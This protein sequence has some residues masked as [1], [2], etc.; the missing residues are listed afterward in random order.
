MRNLSAHPGI[1]LGL[2]RGPIR[3]VR[4]GTCIF[5][6]RA[7]ITYGAGRVRCGTGGVHICP[8]P[9][10]IAPMCKGDRVVNGPVGVP[11]SYCFRSEEESGRNC[12]HFYLLCEVRA[13]TPPVVEWRRGYFKHGAA[14]RPSPGRREGGEGNRGGLIESTIRR[15]H[16]QPQR[17]AL[18]GTVLTRSRLVSWDRRPELAATRREPGRACPRPSPLC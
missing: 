11:T 9:A 10:A 2:V 8:S 4:M 14:G 18:P 7:D 12:S 13:L 3:P 15:R 17:A 16:N 5:G 1:G 6:R